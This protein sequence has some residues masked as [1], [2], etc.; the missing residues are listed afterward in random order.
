[1]VTPLGLRRW[2]RASNLSVSML[3]AT[4][5][6]GTCTYEHQ[7]HT[8]THTHTHMGTRIRSARC[9]IVHSMLFTHPNRP[10][11][12]EAKPHPHPHFHTL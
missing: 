4:R 7:T 6:S 3:M 9:R 11:V 1:M 8:H 2:Y 12:G 5:N 10:A